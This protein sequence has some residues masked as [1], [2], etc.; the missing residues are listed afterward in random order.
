[1]QDYKK[2]PLTFLKI[3]MNEQSLSILYFISFE[4]NSYITLRQA[5]EGGLCMKKFLVVFITTIL[6]TFLIFNWN[7]GE[8]KVIKFF[9]LDPSKNFT[10]YETTLKLFPNPKGKNYQLGWEITSDVIEL[11]YLRQDISLLYADGKLKGLLNQWK[12]D[13]RQLNQQTILNGEGS[14]YFEAISYHHGEIHYPNDVIKSIQ[15]MSFD[16]FFVWDGNQIEGFKESVTQEQH[17]WENHLISKKMGN[18]K[19]YWEELID[20]YDINVKEYLTIPLSD[21][22]HFEDEPFPSLTIEQTQQVIG[23]LWEGIYRHYILGINGEFSEKQNPINTYMPLI[24]VH[25]GGEHLYVLYE[26]TNG[27]KHRLIQQ[28]PDFSEN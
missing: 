20:Y 15:A 3:F 8:M 6:A 14:H 22:W 9:P 21:L 5:F 2:C 27:K 28:I 17:Q 7:G 19:P 26:D 12:Q 10:N 23:Q 11:M 24:L 1:M 18:L 25:K 16:D 13:V 4:N